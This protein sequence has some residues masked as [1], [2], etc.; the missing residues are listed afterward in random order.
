MAAAPLIEIRDLSKSYF[1]EEVETPVLFNLN[2][3][4]EKGEFIS[5]MG[6]SGSGKS[7]L[8][9][10]IGFMDQHTIRQ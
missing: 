4:I 3:K 1:N 7:T 6:P 10:I 9:H 8:M 5:I 2:L